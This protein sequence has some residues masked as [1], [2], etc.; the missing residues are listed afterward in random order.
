M[1]NLLYPAI[2]YELADWLTADWYFMLLKSPFGPDIATQQF[3]ADIVADE[4]TAPGYSRVL[5]TGKA[6][7]T[8]SVTP[9][10][11]YI[12]DDPNFG[13]PTGGQVA[14]YLALYRKVT[15]DA[16]SVV[17]G[18][19]EV[20]LNLDGSAQVVKFLQQI[21]YALNDANP[22]QAWLLTGEVQHLALLSNQQS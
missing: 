22:V 18:V 13:S 6:I 16:D 10:G 17:A 19:W 4:V 21:G 1:N 7:T 11:Q 2:I 5:V 12:Q 20:G 9:W 3:V 8:S 14:T 15:N